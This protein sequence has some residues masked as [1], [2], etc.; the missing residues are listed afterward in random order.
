VQKIVPTPNYGPSQLPGPIGLLLIP[1]FAM[2]TMASAIE[3]L[4]IA[5]R[6]LKTPYQWTLLSLDGE[7]VVDDNGVAILPHT[8][9]ANAPPLG[10]LIV[11][12]DIQPDRYFSGNLK[13]WLQALNAKGV[14]MGALDTGCFLLARAGLLDGRRA[15]MHWEVTDAFKE[16]FPKTVVAQTLYEVGGG[17]LSCA[18]GTAAIDMMLSAIEHDHGVELANRVA[19]HCLHERMRPGDAEQRVAL[20]SRSRIHHPALARAMAL[21]E[22]NPDRTIG[23]QELAGHANLSNRQLLRLFAQFVGEGPARYHRRLRL[24]HARGLLRY[25]AMSVTQAA[26]AVGFESLA[27]FCRAYR[28]QYGLA[29]GSDRGVSVRM[30]TLLRD[31]QPN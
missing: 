12:A 6:Y 24:E 9:I 21:L 19:E 17:R 23:V 29:P 15:T 2:L 10:T 11:C 27:H 20:A 22:K 16:R 31:R 5:N 1:Q 14:T 30:G 13:A 28:Q 26:V 18:G 4:R 8:S 7:A 25:T 3:P